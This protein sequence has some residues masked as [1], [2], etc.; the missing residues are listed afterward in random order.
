ME[1]SVSKTVDNTYTPIVENFRNAAGIGN[2]Y[3]CAKTDGL[4]AKLRLEEGD[5]SRIIQGTDKFLMEEMGLIL[6]LRS[7]SERNEEDSRRWMSQA[8]KTLQVV[9]ADASYRTTSDRCVV[10]IDVLSPP[11]FMAYIEQAWLSS[12]EKAQATWFKLVDGSKLHELRIEKLND[13]GLAG[14]NEA[15]LETGQADLCRALRTMTEHLEANPQHPVAIHC[16]QGKDRT[17]MLV[18]LL[19]S[20]LG[21]SDEIIIDDYFRSN[22]MLSSARRNDGSAAAEG[23]TNESSRQR[24]R[25]KLD[26]NFFSGTNREAMITTLD[27][28]RSKYGT[29]SPGYLDSIGFGDSWRRR[30]VACL[31]V[32]KTDESQPRSKL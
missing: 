4:G 2:V 5:P 22:L 19:Q 12:A 13:L 27:F 17:G 32:S 31:V 30:L 18:M 24:R 9:E 14:L 8:S 25:G 3:R 28:L 16:V 7:P 15:I 6:D 21:I 11:R 1:F 26:R 23:G 29:I 20:L 10:R